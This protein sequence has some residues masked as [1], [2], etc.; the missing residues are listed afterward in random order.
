MNKLLKLPSEQTIGLIVDF[1][2]RCLEQTF[3]YSSDL[4]ADL[5]HL[6]TQNIFKFAIVNCDKA[7]KFAKNALAQIDLQN[8]F[9]VTK[10]L[11]NFVH[12][13]LVRKNY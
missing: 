5:E 2:T 12:I 10:I 8:H 13:C 6:S 3:S 9:F 4:T 7:S 11:L 1:R